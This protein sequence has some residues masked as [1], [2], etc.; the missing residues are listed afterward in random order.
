M[1]KATNFIDLTGKKF[2]RLTVIKRLDNSRTNTA[3][4]LCKCDCGNESIVSTSKLNSC[5]TQSCGCLG[6]E[7]RRSSLIKEA[8]YSAKKSIFNR[9]KSAAR[10]FNREFSLS[11]DDVVSI[12]SNKC[13]Y[14]GIDPLKSVLSH[15]KKYNGDF[16]HN[17]IDRKD[18]SIGYTLD[19]CL[20]C[21]WK[22]NRMKSAT[23]HDDFLLLIKTIYE[24]KELNLYV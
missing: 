19:N 4:W 6:K 17:G 11:L 13:Y 2:S 14:C 22:C 9:Y 23:P 15:S 5:L 18:S 10:K 7:R 20:P 3:R 24:N 8:G 21:C 12:T 1:R 16:L